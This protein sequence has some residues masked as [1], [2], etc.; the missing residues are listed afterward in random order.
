MSVTK[1]TIEAMFAT[2]RATFSGAVITIRHN[3]REYSGTRLPVE[4]GEMVDA[5]GSMFTVTGGVRLMVSELPA[6]WPKAG[7]VASVLELE[8]STWKT[9][10]VVSTRLDEMEATMLLTYGEM[11]DQ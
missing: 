3:A 10:S 1:A 9:Y 11:Y 5:A 7:D 2:A 6:V 8:G 4:K